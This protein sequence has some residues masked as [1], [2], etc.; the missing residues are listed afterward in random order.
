MDGL[1]KVVTCLEALETPE[2]RDPR[3]CGFC[4]HAGNLHTP[5]PIQANLPSVLSNSV[6]YLAGSND[7]RFFRFHCQT[8]VFRG[9]R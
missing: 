3:L 6:P 7:R 8:N 5:P 1:G 4:L 2:I 9:N